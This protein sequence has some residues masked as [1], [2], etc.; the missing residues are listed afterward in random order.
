ML[1]GWDGVLVMT[2]TV[3]LL[4]CPLSGIGGRI[5]YL[6]DTPEMIW[7]YL[8][9]KQFLDAARRYLRATLVHGLLSSYPKAQ[10]AKFPLLTHQWPLVEK[11]KWVVL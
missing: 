3:N 10:L 6:V 9:T 2:L 4:V 7:G 11:F 8:D 5:R 1:T